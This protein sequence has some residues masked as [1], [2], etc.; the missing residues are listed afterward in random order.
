MKRRKHDVKTF[1][2][3]RATQWV[4]FYA[5]AEPRTII[6]QNLNSRQRFTLELVEA[7]IPASSR[8]LD[9]GCGS[10]V[11]AAKLMQRGYAV[12]GI[13][14]AEPMIRQARELCGTDQFGIGDI[15]HIPFED[16]TFDG[17]VSLG[18]IE[19]QESDEPALREI[20]RVLSP[21]GRAVIAI[22]NGRSPVRR[23]DDVALSVVA[24]LRSVY[25]LLKYRLRGRPSPVRG[26]PAGPV[27]RRFHRERWLVLLRSMG[28]EP[29]EWI[30]HGWGWFRS[31][32]GRFIQPLFKT[33]SVVRRGIERLLGPALVSQI[34]DR[35]VRSRARNWLA[36][37]QIVRV[38]AIKEDIGAVVMR[39][40][41]LGR[42]VEAKS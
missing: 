20:H 25:D 39:N 7:A 19:Y 15:E 40:R 23:L 10:G 18:V 27:G 14:L 12:W 28:F 26:I 35:V 6:T 17:V 3:E 13:D 31:P 29:E 21:G 41:Q 8:I 30:C 36:A 32:L 38:R 11:T 1:F 22:P 16:N 2:S 33:R 34:S 37:E 9:A 42:C 24:V 5:D 4:T